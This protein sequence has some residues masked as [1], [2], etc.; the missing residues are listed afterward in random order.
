MLTADQAAAAITRINATFTDIF[1]LV[2]QLGLCV[3]LVAVAAL[4]S[5]ALR[6]RRA[7]FALLRATGFRRADLMLAALAE[8]LLLGL[9][10]IGIGV[11]AGIGTLA[12]LFWTAFGDLAFHPHWGQIGGTAALCA[13]LI[14]ASC[15]V[16]VIRAVRRDPG[17]DL[18][19]VG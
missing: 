6:E 18:L 8:P 10:G 3:A 4:V 15:A 14:I 7:E 16:P 2:L 17:S 5:R 12:L 19:D 1:S 11:V 13:A 9:T